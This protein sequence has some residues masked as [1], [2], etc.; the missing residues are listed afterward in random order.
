MEDLDA[1]DP[2]D[3]VKPEADTGP[4]LPLP[5]LP[6]PEL[7]PAVAP[8]LEVAP[9]QTA[10]RKRGRWPLLLIGLVAA[11]GGAAYATGYVPL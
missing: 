7:L 3:R 8:I 1:L 9:P 4:M 5:E 10:Q 2:D 11:V 6:L